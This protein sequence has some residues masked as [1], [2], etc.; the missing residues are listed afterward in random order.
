MFE[1]G[2][3]AGL[4]CRVIF[5]TCDMKQFEVLAFQIMPDHIH[6]LLYNILPPH[7]AVGAVRLKNGSAGTAARARGYTISD[8][9]HGIK[10][11]YCDAIRDS[12]DMNYPV[13]QKR[14]YTRIVSNRKYLHTVIA[15][16]GHN[17]GKA[18]LP[19]RFRHHPYRRFNRHA[20]IRLF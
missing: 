10:S 17:P 6:L 9:M 2:E 7:P 5:K 4:M 12:Y 16:M 15:Y 14:F 19:A 3:L 13:F 20:I 18:G 11:Y 1:D 8:V